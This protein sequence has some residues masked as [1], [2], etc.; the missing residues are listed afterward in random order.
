MRPA[1]LLL[2]VVPLRNRSSHLA[3]FMARVWR[4]LLDEH[5]NAH[6][7]VAEQSQDGRRFNRGALLNAA[8]HWYRNT[9]G[10]RPARVLLHDV[11]LEPC[12]R[13]RRQ[14][15]AMPS[16]CLAVAYGQRWGRYRGP[17]Y[18]GG[19]VGVSPTVFWRTNGFPNSFWGWG[20]ED[21]AL[22]RRLQAARVRLDKPRVGSFTDLE[23]MTLP[24]K[25]NQLRREGAMC[26]NKRELRNSRCG[27]HQVRYRV[28]RRRQHV[29]QFDLL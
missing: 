15:Y 4:P 21:D 8:L 11:D 28:V 22:Y 25:L 3:S 9:G 20:G 23:N 29:V 24:Q 16:T 13:M 14:Y 1:E 6:L 5:A 10:K 27:I 12:A 2:V 19:V 17:R 18:F 26:P 7:I